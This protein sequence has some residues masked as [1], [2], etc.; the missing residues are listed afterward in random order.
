[1]ITCHVDAQNTNIH[2]LATM[3]QPFLQPQ[4]SIKPLDEL[5]RR[6]VHPKLLLLLLRRHQRRSRRRRPRG[7]NLHA[8]PHRIVMPHQRVALPAATAHPCKLMSR[9]GMP[10][11]MCRDDRG[12]PLPGGIIRRPRRATAAAELVIQGRNI[13][14]G[15]VTL[16]REGLVVAR[17]GVIERLPYALSPPHKILHVD[18]TLGDSVLD[19]EAY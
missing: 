11:S 16:T 14:R 13:R 10:P 18:V 9:R 8:P 4:I 12:E 5:L 1:M 3:I 17:D 19:E 15:G 6:L 2:I 7:G